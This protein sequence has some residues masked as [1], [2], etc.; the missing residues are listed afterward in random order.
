[1]RSAGKAKSNKSVRILAVRIPDAVRRK[2]S[3]VP[4]CCSGIVSVSAIV[5]VPVLQRTTS[6]ECATCCAAPGKQVSIKRQGALQM[7][8]RNLWR[9][10]Q[11]DFG[12]GH[13]GE[14]GISAVMWHLPFIR[15]IAAAPGG[16]VSFPAPPISGASELLAGAPV[17]RF[18][19]RFRG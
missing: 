9:G 13:R 15:A 11:R 7:P 2:R 16:R 12:R 18:R 17:G 8:Y 4:H 3:A 14:P 10:E 1:M 19:V 6:R 5:T